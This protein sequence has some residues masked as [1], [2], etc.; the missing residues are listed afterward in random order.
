MA[1]SRSSAAEQ[2]VQKLVKVSASKASARGIPQATII[3]T[4]GSD[5]EHQAIDGDDWYPDRTITDG[6]IVPLSEAYLLANLVN[7]SI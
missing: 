4:W 7:S 1:G 2:L 5:A 6:D 3:Q